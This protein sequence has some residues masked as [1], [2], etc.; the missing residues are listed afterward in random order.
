MWKTLAEGLNVRWISVPVVHL[1]EQFAVPSTH[2]RRHASFRNAGE[3]QLTTRIQTS[4]SK[5]PALFEEDCASCGQGPGPDE[6]R[7]GCQ[8]HGP[9]WATLI[10]RQLLAG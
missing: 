7:N 10:N 9:P 3:Q 5:A 4:N 8:E 2:L 1:V 6:S